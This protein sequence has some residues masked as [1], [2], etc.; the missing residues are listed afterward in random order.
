VAGGSVLWRVTADGVVALNL[1]ESLK[2]VKVT[3]LVAY[4]WY[5]PRSN[6]DALLTT[7]DNKGIYSLLNSLAPEAGMRAPFYGS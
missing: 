3:D 5:P 7:Q 1:S 6:V 2:D 4:P